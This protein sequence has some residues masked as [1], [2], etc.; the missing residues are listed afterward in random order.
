MAADGGPPQDTH[1]GFQI[2]GLSRK[3]GVTLVPD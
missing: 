3:D 2:A 1:P